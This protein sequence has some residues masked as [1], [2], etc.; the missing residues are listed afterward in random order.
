[1]GGAELCHGPEAGVGPVCRGSGTPTGPVEEVAAGRAQAGS[2]GLSRM[3]AAQTQ[4]A[5]VG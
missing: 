3:W 1:M 4:V 2:R 5:A